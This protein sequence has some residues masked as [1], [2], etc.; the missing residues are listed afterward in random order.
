M[1]LRASLE[2]LNILNPRPRPVVD[3]DTVVDAAVLKFVEDGK[4]RTPESLVRD[5]ADYVL[6]AS[7]Q[8]EVKR[9]EITG[10]T[11]ELNG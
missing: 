1:G 6:W 3:R 5:V 4:H 10:G 7:E 11:E 9:A 2:I 8:Y